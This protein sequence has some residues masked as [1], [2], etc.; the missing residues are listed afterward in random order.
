MRWPFC[1]LAIITLAACSKI[2][3]AGQADAAAKP[4]APAS[5]PMEIVPNKTLL[6]RL[7]IGEPAW[8]RSEPASPLPRRSTSTIRASPGSVRP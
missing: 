7:K 6:D 3:Q 5:D 1:V 2:K 8:P 4:A